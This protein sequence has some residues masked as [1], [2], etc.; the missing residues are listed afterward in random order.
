M[1][2]LWSP[3][4]CPKVGELKIYI[5]YA[6]VNNVLTG[7]SVCVF[8]GGVCMGVAEGLVDGGGIEG[9]PKPPPQPLL[10]HLTHHLPPGHH[11][12]QQDKV[13]FPH[14]CTAIFFSLHH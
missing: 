10:T 1:D 2:M 7:R 13:S 6:D 9:H 8:S 3:I 14:F 11:G 12:T 4:V 5:Y